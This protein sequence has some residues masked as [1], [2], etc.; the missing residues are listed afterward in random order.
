[1]IKASFSPLETPK[2]FHGETLSDLSP[3]HTRPRFICVYTVLYILVLC[4]VYIFACHDQYCFM[5]CGGMSIGLSLMLRSPPSVTS[6]YSN[7]IT[8][9]KSYKSFWQKL[10]QSAITNH[11][12]LSS[13]HWTPPLALFHIPVVYCINKIVPKS[14][15]LSSLWCTMHFFVLNQSPKFVFENICLCSSCISYLNFAIVALLLLHLTKLNKDFDSS[16]VDEEVV[17][18]LLSFKEH[19]SEAFFYVRILSCTHIYTQTRPALKCSV[20]S[21]HIAHQEHRD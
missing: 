1:M 4:G 13:Q 18:H 14:I 12:K 9:T 2:D 6:L 7:W 8:K 16:T 21:S 11:R 19:K 3:G 20:C 10:T 15:I 5:C 17:W